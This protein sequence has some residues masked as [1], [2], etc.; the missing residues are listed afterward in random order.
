[1]SRSELSKKIEQGIRKAVA[2]A[3]TRHKKLGQSIAVWQD[4]KVVIIPAS[5]I[6][7]PSV[8]KSKKNNKK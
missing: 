4:N 1:M 2:V 7:V 5:K 3:L 8:M 6:K